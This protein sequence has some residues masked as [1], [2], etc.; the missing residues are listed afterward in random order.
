[1][2]RESSDPSFAFYAEA[3]VDAP[4]IWGAFRDLSR[5]LLGSSAT[6]LI[7]EIDENPIPLGAAQTGIILGLLEPYA[8]QLAHDGLIQFGLGARTDR[9]I[10][11]V[12]VTPTKH[13]KVWLNDEI[14]F[15]SV[16][17]AH[18]IERPESLQFIDEYPRTTTPLSAE[19]TS[20]ADHA[21]LF[22]HLR[23]KLK[24]NS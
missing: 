10:T 19:Q 7:G 21:S 6:L 3:N 8:Y 22:E 9:G 15:E 2:L 17:Q 14:E 20:F 13:F 18:A 16:M 4:K 24:G 12:F 5:G 23:T 1:V 11:E